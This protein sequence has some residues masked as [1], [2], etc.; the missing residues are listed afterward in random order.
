MRPALIR[1]LTQTSEAETPRALRQ[2]IF[3]T[4]GLVGNEHD[5]FKIVQQDLGKS[6]LFTVGIG[7][8]PNSHFMR[9]AA[10]F[11]KGPFTFIGNQAPNI[12]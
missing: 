10:E 4:D 2:I 12:I 9:K 7:S 6:R 3:I 8:A 11:G 1:A 5:L